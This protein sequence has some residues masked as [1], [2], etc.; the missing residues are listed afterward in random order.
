M[1]EILACL[2]L[3][4]LAA[5]DQSAQAPP[6]ASEASST[7]SSSTVVVSAG[8]AAGPVRCV[9]TGLPSPGSRLVQSAR[10]APVPAPVC[11]VPLSV[12]ESATDSVPGL[13]SDSGSVSS[14]SLGPHLDQVDQP[15][16]VGP[17]G[18]GCPSPAI[19]SSGT[20]GADPGAASAGADSGGGAV[21]GSI[22]HGSLPLVPP[23]LPLGRTTYFTGPALC[24]SP[25]AGPAC[26]AHLSPAAGELQLFTYMQGSWY[27]TTYHIGTAV[28]LALWPVV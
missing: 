22:V 21:A 17:L 10:R 26:F 15:A 27:V 25:P 3:L 4:V 1:G 9:P 16:R 14:G 12:C 23:F 8:L 6:A 11:E 20:L 28:P 18:A 5:V 7:A 2:R 13:V 24:A 19:C